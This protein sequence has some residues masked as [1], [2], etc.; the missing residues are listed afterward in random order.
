MLLA[1][2][3]STQVDWP[4]LRDRG[5]SVPFVPVLDSSDDVSYF[6]RKPSRDGS[7]MNSHGSRLVVRWSRRPHVSRSCGAAHTAHPSAQNTDDIDADIEEET[8]FLNFEYSNVASLMQVRHDICST[9]EEG[10]YIDNR[11]REACCRSCVSS[12]PP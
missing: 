8:E 10:V 3:P 12:A 7:K 1:A 4:L 9:R 11:V 2:Y 5:V 6:I